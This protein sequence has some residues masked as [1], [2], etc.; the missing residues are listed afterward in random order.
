MSFSSKVIT[1]T[2]TD[3]HTSHRLLC[4]EVSIKWVKWNNE[5]APVSLEA[6]RMLGGQDRW[7]RRHWTRSSDLRRR[8]QAACRVPTAVSPCRAIASSHRLAG[9]EPP[10]TIKQSINQAL[11]IVA[12]PLLHTG[13]VGEEFLPKR[14][15]IHQL[16]NIVKNYYDKNWQ[17]VRKCSRMRRFP[18]KI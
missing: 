16:E 3:R 8:R 2:H 6:G 7:R 10:S 14:S 17:W 5:I 12:I 4:V 15:V 13:C 18:L 9:H 11:S 1:D